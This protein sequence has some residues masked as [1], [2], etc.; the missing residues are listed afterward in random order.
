MENTKII[1]ALNTL[2]IINNDRIEGY[3]TASSETDQ[4]D[5]RE[6]FYQFEQT[7]LLCKSELVA[8]IHRLD[9]TVD[10]GT[11]TTGKFFR[12]WMEVKAALTGGDRQAILS[13]CDYGRAWLSTLITQR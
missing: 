12:I 7:S 10:E 8:E 13:S 2:L 4:T 6:M 5:L 11:R 9:G 3:V 1:D